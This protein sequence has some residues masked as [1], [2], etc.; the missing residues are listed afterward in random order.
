MGDEV[1]GTL[2]ITYTPDHGGDQIV[3]RNVLESD[4]E[5]LRSAAVS[6]TVRT[7]DGSAS[8][9]TLG[10]RATVFKRNK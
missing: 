5:K 3:I 1:Y 9:D 7:R 10:I 8:V 4:L 2:T 6:A